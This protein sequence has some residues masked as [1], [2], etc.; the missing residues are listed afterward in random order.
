MSENTFFTRVVKEWNTLSENIETS[1][2]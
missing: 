2:L 1:P